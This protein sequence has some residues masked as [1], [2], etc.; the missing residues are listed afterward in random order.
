MTARNA[1]S[2]GGIVSGIVLIGFGI[3][4]IVLAANGRSTVHSEL[5]QQRITGSP[6]MTPAAVKA[7]VAKAGLADVTLPTCNVAGQSIDTGQKARCFAEYMNVH[8]LEATGGYTYAEMG[9]YT[10]KPDTPKSELEPGGGTSNVEYAEPD[11]ETGKPVQNASR[12]VWVTET[13]LA[14]ALNMSYMANRLSLFS[15]V[16]GVALLLTGIGFIV[17]VTA[18]ALLGDASRH[19]RAGAPEGTKTLPAR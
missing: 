5:K 18:G 12:N 19:E 8:A 3:V 1:F 11:P 17:L 15:L 10:A 7:E 16:V 4:V 6:D 14:T 13:A 2:I 9:I